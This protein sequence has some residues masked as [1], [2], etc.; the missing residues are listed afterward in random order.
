[1]TPATSSSVRAACSMPRCRNIGP[2]GSAKALISR[3]LTTSNEYRNAGCANRAGTA[4]TSRRPILSTSASVGRIV[5]LRQL[6][7]HMRRRLTS[8]LN[9]LGGLEAVSARLDSRLAP[10]RST[11]TST[12]ARPT[13]TLRSQTLESCLTGFSKCGSARACLKRVCFAAEVY[14]SCDTRLRTGSPSVLV[15]MARV[16]A[17][18]YRFLSPSPIKPMA[19]PPRKF[20]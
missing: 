5:Q 15:L 6:T 10:R 18:G 9:V 2:P 4:A 3:R 11:L 7:T 17:G 19:H 12:P 1:M 16:G 8:E 20:V 13:L 14:N